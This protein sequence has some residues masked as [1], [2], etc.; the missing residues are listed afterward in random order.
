M[1]AFFTGYV[2]VPEFWAGIAWP[3]WDYTFFFPPRSL[4]CVV[5]WWHLACTLPRSPGLGLLSTVFQPCHPYLHPVNKSCW[6]RRAPY[7]DGLPPLSNHCALGSLNRTEFLTLSREMF[8][9]I[10]GQR[11]VHMLFFSAGDSQ[12]FASDQFIRWHVSIK[13]TPISWC[14]WKLAWR[15]WCVLP[16]CENTEYKFFTCGVSSSFG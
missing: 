16:N 13:H 3:C 12:H 10:E 11:T 9:G 4:V 7:L 15:T 8:T 6:E 5:W 2:S 14:L 1:Q